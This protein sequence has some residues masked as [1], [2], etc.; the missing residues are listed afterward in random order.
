MAVHS[1]KSV[2]GENFRRGQCDVYSSRNGWTT[3]TTPPPL[4]P[5]IK[6]RYEGAGFEVI[7]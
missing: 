4:N 5:A 6:G 2:D 1:V 7:S 3:S